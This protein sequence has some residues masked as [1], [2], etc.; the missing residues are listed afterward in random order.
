MIT[1]FN[2]FIAG[3]TPKQEMRIKIGLA[4]VAHNNV[5]PNSYLLSFYGFT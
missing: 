2:F 1:L 4:I 5:P 3:S